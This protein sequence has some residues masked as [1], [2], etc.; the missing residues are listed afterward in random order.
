MEGG[1]G[2]ELPQRGAGDEIRDV[3]GVE[4]RMARGGGVTAA[5]SAIAFVAKGD[6]GGGC[7]EDGGVEGGESGVV[8]VCVVGGVDDTVC[9]KYYE[10]QTSV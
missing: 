7:G 8:A 1:D 4:V 5:A 6:C 9:V 3:G 10:G 2:L